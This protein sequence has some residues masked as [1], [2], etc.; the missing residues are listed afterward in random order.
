MDCKLC[1]R[2][3]QNFPIVYELTTLSNTYPAPIHWKYVEQK[4]FYWMT[5]RHCYNSFDVSKQ[6]SSLFNNAIYQI[7]FLC[8]ML[9]D[10]VWED[11]TGYCEILCNCSTRKYS[12][13]LLVQLLWWIPLLMFTSMLYGC[14]RDNFFESIKIYSVFWLLYNI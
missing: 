4:Y 14:C 11:G 6:S 7:L 10:R 12:F 13:L 2:N 3:T 8:F 1:P 5:N 9:V